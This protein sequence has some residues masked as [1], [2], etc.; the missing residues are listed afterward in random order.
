MLKSATTMGEVFS[1]SL[2]EPL[3]IATFLPYK[4]TKWGC[5]GISKEDLYKPTMACL[6]SCRLAIR[7]LTYWGSILRCPLLLCTFVLF[8]RNSY[9][10]MVVSFA[11][12]VSGIHRFLNSGGGCFGS[13]LSNRHVLLSTQR[14]PASS[15]LSINSKWCAIRSYSNSS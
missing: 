14:L 12:P 9:V 5:V 2:S 6:L 10:T 3:A 4:G 11:E 8:K 13:L 7:E 15:L 1:V